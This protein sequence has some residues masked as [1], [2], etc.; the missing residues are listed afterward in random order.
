MKTVKE[1][2]KSIQITE[3]ASNVFPE[4]LFRNV[5]PFH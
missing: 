3:L 1:K 5:E 4:F 2:N